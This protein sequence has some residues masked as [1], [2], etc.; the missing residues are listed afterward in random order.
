MAVQEWALSSALEQLRRDAR[1]PTAPPEGR[2]ALFVYGLAQLPLGLRMVVREPELRRRAIGPVVVVTCVCIF[3]A[4]AE[5]R[6][7]GPLGGIATFFVTL[8]A[9]A[10]MPPIL[11]A[12][13]FTRLAVAVR[14]RLG[15]GPRRPNLRPLRSLVAETVLQALVLALGIL[16]LLALAEVVPGV[17]GVLALALGG[18]WTLHWIVVEAFDSARTLPVGPA[19][20]RAI[21]AP[22][23]VR[24]YG[25]SLRG[26][27][28]G[29][30]RA[31]GR[32]AARLGGRWDREVALVEAEPWLA[33]GFA[34]GAAV[35]LA[36]P[37]FN[38]L[39]RP[40]VVVA[41]AH[42]CGRLEARDVRAAEQSS[43]YP[44]G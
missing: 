11:F 20:D 23:F 41:A 13:S 36:I 29:P 2:L 16:P 40:A 10:S 37:G 6:G 19:M 21:A 4:T 1:E 12:G 43:E 38:L 30:L 5:G 34:T 39:F 3:A 28:I 17:G 24:M 9:I 35:L 44:A 14:D 33:A 7:G 18:A 42:V 32:L 25:V 8:V 22:W 27:T 15:L 31:Y 26:R